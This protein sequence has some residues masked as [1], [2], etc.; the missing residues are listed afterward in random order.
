ML[1]YLN[2]VKVKEKEKL[3]ARIFTDLQKNGDILFHSLMA[4]ILEFEGGKKMGQQKNS[5]IRCGIYEGLMRGWI[6]FFCS[7]F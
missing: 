1:K 6:P 4:E 7:Q 5:R 3:K 2:E